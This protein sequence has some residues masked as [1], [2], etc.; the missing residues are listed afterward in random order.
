MV[1]GRAKGGVT[2]WVRFG[3][4]A[5]RYLY[6]VIASACLAFVK[7]GRL[8]GGYKGGGPLVCFF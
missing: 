1:G 8:V 6:R 7:V 2:A 4:R 5:T 3:V